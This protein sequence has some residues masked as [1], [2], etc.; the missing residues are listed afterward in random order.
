MRGPGNKAAIATAAS[1]AK[2]T[3]RAPSSATVSDETH[4][5]RHAAAAF[6]SRRRRRSLLRSRVLASATPVRGPRPAALV[7]GARATASGVDLT[8]WKQQSP[9]VAQVGPSGRLPASSARRPIATTLL[10]RARP[11]ICGGEQVRARPPPD[12][13]P[14]AIALR[15]S[16]CRAKRV[17]CQAARHGFQ[18]CRTQVSDRRG[19]SVLLDCECVCGAD[20]GRA[21]SAGCRGPGPG[22][23]STHPPPLGPVAAS[24]RYGTRDKG[25]VNAVG[26]ERNRAAPGCV[27]IATVPEAERSSEIR[28]GLC[29]SGREYVLEL[30]RC[31]AGRDWDT[32]GSIGVLPAH[33][34][35]GFDWS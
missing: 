16:E 8:T 15:R 28:T 31:A 10:S 17:S 14:R 35:C 20:H 13:R 4:A 6:T 23:A 25:G 21:G 27:W 22:R 5:P 29:S 9:A 30:I 3:T 32:I 34:N 1:T 7:L 11:P 24:R 2:E 19:A 26:R 18:T 12:R 33:R